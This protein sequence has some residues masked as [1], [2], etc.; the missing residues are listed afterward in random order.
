MPILG[1]ISKRPAY[2]IASGGK[3]K[4]RM[5]KFFYYIF[6]LCMVVILLSVGFYLGDF[7]L[8]N[9]NALDVQTDKSSTYIDRIIDEEA[10]V[11][12][13]IYRQESISCLPISDTLLGRQTGR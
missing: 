6:L 9:D 13:W 10:G 5:D 4:S 2:Q 11:V 3:V 7:L 8:G 1:P 12:C